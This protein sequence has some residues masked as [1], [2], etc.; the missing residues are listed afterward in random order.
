MTDAYDGSSWLHKVMNASIFL[1][2][3]D[4]TYG[5]LKHTAQVPAA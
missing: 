4:N 3:E 1:T 5:V 2:R